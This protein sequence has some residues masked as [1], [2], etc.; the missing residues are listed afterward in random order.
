MY[1]T[2]IATHIELLQYEHIAGLRFVG[3]PLV[4]AIVE[5]YNELGAKYKEE[6]KEL[7][8]MLEKMLHLHKG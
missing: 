7:V 8:E 4:K 2:Y 1:V 3:E 6:F 5:A